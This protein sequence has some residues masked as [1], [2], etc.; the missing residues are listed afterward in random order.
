MRITTT[1]NH[2]GADPLVVTASHRKLALYAAALVGFLLV[3]LFL[4]VAPPLHDTPWRQGAQGVVGTVG[5]VASLIGLIVLL[6]VVPK[7][8][9]AVGHDGLFYHP[10][11][12]ALPFDEIAEMGVIRQA[13]ASTLPLTN[14]FDAQA[15]HFRLKDEGRFLNGEA[16]QRRRKYYINDELQLS[17]T[18]LSAR[19][20]Q[21]VV[22]RLSVELRRSNPAISIVYT[23]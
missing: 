13:N 3:S 9:I 18:A 21:R 5:L 19:D 17:L 16:G 10:G 11:N 20:F 15:L 7:T 4:I 2:L 14:A 6:R 1:A 12:F 22:D 8:A 23:E